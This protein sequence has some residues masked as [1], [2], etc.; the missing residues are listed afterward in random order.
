MSVLAAL[1]LA[2]VPAAVPAAQADEIV[3]IGERLKAWRGKFG[4]KDGVASC[5]TTKSTGDREIDAIGCNALVACITPHASQMQAIADMK[6]P[7]A[8]RNRRLNDAMQPVGPC[9]VEKRGDAIA[10]LAARRAGA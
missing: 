5:R 7:K 6:L 8:E 4:T 3:V 1:L 9:L 2:T 10:N